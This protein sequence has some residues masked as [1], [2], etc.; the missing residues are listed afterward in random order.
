MSRK[1]LS[2]LCLA[3]LALLIVFLI[4]QPEPVDTESPADDSPARVRPP[5]TSGQQVEPRLS[6]F[7][8]PVA[9]EIRPHPLLKEGNLENGLRYQ[10]L[11]LPNPDR[12]ISLRLVF[13]VGSFMEEDHERGIAHFL[14]HLVFNGTRH[15]PQGRAMEEF[16]RLGLK[17][18]QH[19]NASTSYE[20]TIYKLD[21]PDDS[22]ETLTPALLFFR[23]V[24]DGLLLRENEINAERDVVLEEMNQRSPLRKR[25]HSPLELLFP[26]TL[27]AKR[28]PIGTPETI[29][30]FTR[31]DFTR[32][33][34]K[35]YTPNRGT[36]I[37]TGDIDP[38]NAQVLIEK[39][40]SSLPWRKREPT[41]HRGE[42]PPDDFLLADILLDDSADRI[43]LY[44]AIPPPE[45]KTTPA[46]FRTALIDDLVHEMVEARWQNILKSECTTR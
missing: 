45:T 21:L 42:L 36:F 23:D 4:L 12:Q 30:A 20:H 11:T 32:F 3:L 10:I 16:Q 15:F 1:K 27:F 25:R 34:Q 9:D 39:H 37:I 44:S 31:T 6:D 46:G 41:P 13:D 28:S 29:A 22:P 17:S 18:G 5:S 33:H 40:F 43:S 19:A 2:T 8:T 14:E 26:N 24:F 35:W 38:D 7:L